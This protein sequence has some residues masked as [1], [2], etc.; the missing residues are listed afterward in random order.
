[1]YIQ[2][3]T[4]IHSYRHTY[5]NAHIHTYTYINIYIYIY[6]QTCMDHMI[7]FLSDYISIC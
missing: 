7:I 1:M 3:S 6:A 5:I 4:H 2:R